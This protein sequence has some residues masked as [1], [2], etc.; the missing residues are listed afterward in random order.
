MKC[1]LNIKKK[2]KNFHYVN[3]FKIVKKKSFIFNILFF[4]T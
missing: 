1:L 4:F 2:K 3:L